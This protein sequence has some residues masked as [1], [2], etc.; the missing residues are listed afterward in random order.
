LCHSI[1]LVE[2]ENCDLL[3]RLVA[4]IDGTVKAA[5]RFIPIDLDGLKL[6]ALPKATITVFDG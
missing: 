1:G 5:T 4:N 6:D 3:I 2:K